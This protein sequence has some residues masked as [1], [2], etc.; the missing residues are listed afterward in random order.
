MWLCF[1]GEGLKRHPLLCSLG[2]D[3]TLHLTPCLRA[4]KADAHLPTG[5][6]KQQQKITTA[7]PMSGTNISA[8]LKENSALKMSKCSTLALVATCKTD[9][10]EFHSL[11][12]QQTRRQ[13]CVAACCVHQRIGAHYKPS[14]WFT[15]SDFTRQHHVTAATKTPAAGG[16]VTPG[17]C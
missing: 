2:Q 7:E 4:G 14:F 5:A 10:D 13:S 1:W 12:A 15:S 6:Q 8:D 16:H 3:P 17:S 11:S 9:P